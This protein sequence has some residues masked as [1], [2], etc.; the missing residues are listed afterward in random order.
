MKF[1]ASYLTPLLVFAGLC[2]PLLA[3]KKAEGEA[4]KAGKPAFA[5]SQPE[6]RW[7][8]QL[9][10]KQFYVLR[11]K[12]T[13]RAF[14]GAFW[15]HKEKGAY[16]CA[17]C[18]QPLFGSATKYDSGCGWPSFWQSEEAA[19]IVIEKDTS[20][21]MVREEVLC[22]R[23]GGHLG[24]VFDDGPKPTGLRYCINSAALQFKPE[25]GNKMTQNKK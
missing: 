8:E 12:G 21:G 1:S 20:H 17:G 10:E 16:L 4:P 25:G 11:Q 24:H 15:D 2:Y 14:T 3:Q 5:V 7:K 13:E 23:C 22:G 9:T 19:N 18:S 6:A